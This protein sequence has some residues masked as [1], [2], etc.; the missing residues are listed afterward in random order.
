[1]LEKNSCSS[2]FTRCSVYMTTFSPFYDRVL[3]V[4]NYLS[5]YLLDYNALRLSGSLFL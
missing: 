5:M 2:M 1:M 4:P 3:S